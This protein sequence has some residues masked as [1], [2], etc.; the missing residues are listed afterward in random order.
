VGQKPQVHSSYK[1]AYA[2][3]AVGSRCKT[4]VIGD[5]KNPDGILIRL[6]G[7][8]AKIPSLKNQKIKGMNVLRGEAK[9]RL[10]LATDIVRVAMKRF[11]LPTYEENVPI[12]CLVRCS[13]RG[14]SFDEDNVATTIKD[15]LEPRYIR[16]HDRGWGLGIVP[17]DKEVNV[18]AVKKVKADPDSDITEIYILPLKY[19]LGYRAEFVEKIM[20][21]FK[22]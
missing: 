17:N 1:A 16:N 14:R 21:L 7:P 5:D 2:K 11:A 9:A 4:L 20:N 10:V 15:W 6:A 8:V 3:Y 13:Y 12:F 19:I 22:I 18:F